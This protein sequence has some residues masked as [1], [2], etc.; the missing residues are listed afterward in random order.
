M[1]TAPIAIFG[2]DRPDHL[3]KMVESLILNEESKNSNVFFFVDGPTD[4]TDLKKHERVVEFASKKFPFKKQETIIRD[5]NVSCK[6]NII[7]GI[8]EVL[9]SNDSIIVL[10]D[11]LILG[12]YFLNY[13]NLSLKHYK[14][15][16]KI[17]HINGYAHPQLLKNKQSASLSVLCQPWGWGTW[18]N[19]WDKFIENKYY[20]KNI[21]STL[22]D[23]ERKKYN[24][25]DLATY[26]E[27]ALKLDQINKNSI[28]DAY[29]YQ[30]VFL[31]NGLTVFPQQ[32]HVQNSGFDG[33]GIHCGVNNDFDTE[34]NN[35][36]T[37]KFPKKIKESK[38]YRFNTYLFYKK[39]STRRYFRYHKEKISSFKNFRS[40]LIKKVS[41]IFE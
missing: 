17:W 10:E 37:K 3:Q 12:N 32:S 26:W 6:F 8:S 27:S 20:E 4:K 11:D 24:F 13:M 38:I 39:Y 31:N 25:Y 18:N 35:K 15:I 16:D 19:R 14:E 5:K 9:E 36:K 33:S 40:F 41:S 29:W 30:T 1:D 28:W 21:I 22:E 23:S 7:T 2:Y 34:I